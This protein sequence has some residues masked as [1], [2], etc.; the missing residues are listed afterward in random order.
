MI[1]K[2]NNRNR[3]SKYKVDIIDEDKYNLEVNC[4]TY[5]HP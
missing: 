2:E 5:L 4:N 1:K 3:L